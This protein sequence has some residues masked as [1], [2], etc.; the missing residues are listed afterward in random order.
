[1]VYPGLSSP[2]SNWLD[3]WVKAS[4]EDSV[5]A[6]ARGSRRSV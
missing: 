5:M 1:M 3:G 6:L 4:T 2:R